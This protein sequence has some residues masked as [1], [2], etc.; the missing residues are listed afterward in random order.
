L[1]KPEYRI[2]RTDFAELGYVPHLQQTDRSGILL[3]VANDKKRN[4]IQ[5]AQEDIH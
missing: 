3:I 2:E 4:S 5:D 1:W